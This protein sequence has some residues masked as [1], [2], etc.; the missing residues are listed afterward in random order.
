MHNRSTLTAARHAQSSNARLVV[1]GGAGLYAVTPEKAQQYREAIRDA[2]YA[3]NDVL[4][5]GGSALNAVVAAVTVLEDNPLFNAGKGACFNIAGKHE[6]E[7][8]VAVSDP[9]K[10]H[11]LPSSR[12][13]AGVTL[14]K[15]VKNPIKLARELYL[16]DK[17]CPHVFLSGPDAERIADEAGLDMVDEHY[18]DTKSAWEEHKRGLD[19]GEKIGVYEATRKLGL[20]T[21]T[22][23]AVGECVPE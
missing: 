23:G 6:L 7:A 9:P 17:T 20:P 12:R 8:S 21:G 1:H 10:G 4:S 14:L 15:H 19:L 16:D 2:L 22:V 3:G 11:D 5:A 18:F 13:G